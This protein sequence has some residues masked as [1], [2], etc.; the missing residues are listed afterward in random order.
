MHTKTVNNTAKTVVCYIFRIKSGIYKQRKNTPTKFKK[1]CNIFVDKY[2]RK[3]T[4]LQPSL[5]RKSQVKITATCVKI[6][7]Q[8]S[9]KKYFSPYVKQ[10]LNARFFVR[11]NVKPAIHP[12]QSYSKSKAR[13][14]HFRM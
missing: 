4:E 5:Y 2:S 14:E 8:Q 6:L 3:R 9:S 12:E 10:N 1:N 11:V 13:S 7:K